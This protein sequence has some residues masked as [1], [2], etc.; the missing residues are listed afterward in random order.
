VA[1]LRQ[2]TLADVPVLEALIAESARDLCQGDYT[3]AQIEAAIGTAWGVDR[4]LIRDGTY[5]VVE[6]D[7]AIVACGGWS[8]RRTLFGGDAQPGRQS[9]VLDP[10]RDAARIRA[11]FVR[12]DWARRGL[13]VMLLERCE[14]EARAHGFRSAELVATLPGQRL[15]RA[16]GYIGDERVEYPLPGGLTI[17]FVPMRKPHLASVG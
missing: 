12:P 2:A 14:A 11:F 13:G 8:K 6:S 17:T 15:Y 7:G 9:E 1:T 3:G 4:E 16:F 10:T 5:F